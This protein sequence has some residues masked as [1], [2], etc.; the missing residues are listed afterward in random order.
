STPTP[1]PDSPQ[2][3]D[4]RGTVSRGGSTYIDVLS[5]DES[6]AGDLSIIDVSPGQFG[7]TGIDDGGVVYYHGGEGEGRDRFTYTIEDEAGETATANVV[8]AIAEPPEPEPPEP[9][10]VPN[11]PPDG[12]RLSFDLREGEGITI[13]LLEGAYDPD[14]QDIV[15]LG[16]IGNNSSIGGQLVNNGDGSVTYIPWERESRAPLARPVA[17]RFQYELVD[18]RGGSFLATL[19]LVIYPAEQDSVDD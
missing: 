7:Q 15:S 16:A 6:A 5:N 18:G 11:R 2:A 8:I 14:L 3:A 4:D 9:E 12:P 10:P 17:N 1:E 13:N 19:Q